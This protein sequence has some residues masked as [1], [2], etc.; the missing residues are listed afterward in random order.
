MD[1]VKTNNN[2]SNLEW[3]TGSEN[4]AH[5]K[6]NGRLGLGRGLTFYD[7]WHPIES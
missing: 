6:V 4:I 7:K 1:C 2:A 5:A 3:V